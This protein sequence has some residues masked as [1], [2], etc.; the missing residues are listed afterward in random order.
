MDYK[1]ARGTYDIFGSGAA[2]RNDIVSNMSVIATNYGFENAQTPIFEHSELFLRSVGSTSDIVSK[3]MY[4]FEDKKQR[5]LTLRPELTAPIARMYINNKLYATNPVSKF[6]YFGPAFRY[7]R[8]QKGRFRQ[9]NQFGVESF[10][11]KKPSVDAEIISLFSNVLHSFNIQNYIIYINS[12][13][14]TT[15]REIYTEELVKYFSQHLDVM[16]NDCCLRLEQNPLR[17]LDCKV[18]KDKIHQISAP[19]IL[20]Y[21][22][23]ES[24]DYFE[25]VCNNL[26]EMGIEFFIDNRLVRGLDYYNDTVFEVHDSSGLAIGGGGRYDGL[27]GQLSNQDVPAFGF[28]IGYERFEGIILEQNPDLI[29]KY[30]KTCDIY[31]A[32]LTEDAISISCSSIHKIRKSGSNAVMNHEIKS[33]KFNIKTATKLGAVYMII[34]GEDEIQSNTVKVKNLLTREEVEVNLSEFEQDIIEEGENHE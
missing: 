20:D 24:K 21:I 11:Q 26:K 7:E 10:G 4:T 16:C 14:T 30:E 9:F 32:P 25:A 8:P 28:A 6:F 18:C 23:Q 31:Y 29:N 15:D 17:I 2:L 3:E 1:L 22:S 12:I 5:S 19:N 34:I 27:I 33:L 13:G